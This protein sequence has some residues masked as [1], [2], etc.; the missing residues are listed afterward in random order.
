MNSRS[1]DRWAHTY[2]HSMAWFP[3]L[4]SKDTHRHHPP[5]PHPLYSTE[6]RPIFS[7][8]GPVSCLELERWQPPSL[9][10]WKFLDF[11]SHFPVQLQ[12][13]CMDKDPRSQLLRLPYMSQG[14]LFLTPT[15]PQLLGKTLVPHLPGQ[16]SFLTPLAVITKGS[17]PIS[18]EGPFPDSLL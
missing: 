7:L 17:G 6:P 18:W 3:S 14:T 9:S 5:P 15:P 11:F 12:L 13:D 16:A 10:C 2:S 4:S 8:L 1:R